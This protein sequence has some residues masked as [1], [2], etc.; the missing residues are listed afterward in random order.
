MENG[1]NLNW[2]NKML[3]LCRRYALGLFVGVSLFGIIGCTEA[4]PP[5]DPNAPIGIVVSQMMI[6]VENKAGLALNNV[7]VAIEPVGGATEFTSFIGRMENSS[8]KDIMLGSFG[9]RDGTPFNLRVVRPKLVRVTAEDINS[10]E[11]D[12]VAPWPQ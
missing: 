9:G 8:K 10:I 3:N 12:I 5:L 2:E 4:V 1:R 11:Y 7:S 6:S